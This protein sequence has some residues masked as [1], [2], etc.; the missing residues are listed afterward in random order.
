MSS[1]GEIRADSNI[2]LLSSISKYFS[3]I[4]DSFAA[5]KYASHPPEIAD[6]VQLCPR[7][8]QGMTDFRVD[9]ASIVHP[10]VSW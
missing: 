5:Q 10:P 6:V 1:D 7:E 4:S 3:L 2:T 9:K 8:R